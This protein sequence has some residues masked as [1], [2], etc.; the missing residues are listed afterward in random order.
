[1]QELFQCRMS[2]PLLGLVSRLT[3]QH[4]S[5]RINVHVGYLLNQTAASGSRY[6]CWRGLSIS[7]EIGS[8]NIK[9]I[10]AV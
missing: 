3:P 4:N 9:H 7:L 8:N 6:V 1:V 5:S 10:L 2:I